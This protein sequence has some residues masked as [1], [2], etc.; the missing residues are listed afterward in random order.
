MAASILWASSSSG[1]S[2]LTVPSMELP[3]LDIL[4]SDPQRAANE[5]SIYRR[6]ISDMK[7][8]LSRFDPSEPQELE[9]KVFFFSEIST[10]F[11]PTQKPS[12]IASLEKLSPVIGDEGGAIARAARTAVADFQKALR[13]GVLADEKASLKDLESALES[14]FVELQKHDD[15]LKVP[16]PKDIGNGSF[17]GVLPAIK[18]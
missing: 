9:E 15:R 8:M 14:A 4:Q 12:L 13:A 10:F 6:P 7:R 11:S 17:F 16:P 1:A 2:A 5:L 3:T 18:A